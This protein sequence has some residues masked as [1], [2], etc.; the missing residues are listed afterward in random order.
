MSDT[1]DT[2]RRFLPDT[3]CLVAILSAGHP[4]HSLARNEVDRRLEGGQLMTLASHCLV[5][6]Y[7]VLTGIPRPHRIA[8]RDVVQ[9]LADRFIASAETVALDAAAYA[10]ILERAPK[11]G[12]VGGRIYDALIAACAVGARVDA[13][14]TFNA[15]HFRSLLPDSIEVVVPR[16]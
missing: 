3:N 2:P 5:E 15:R 13:L 14:I 10:E 7:A 1:A 9:Q 12:I 16:E 4:H 8:P 6:T 11:R